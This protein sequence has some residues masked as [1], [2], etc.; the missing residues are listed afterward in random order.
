MHATARAYKT[1]IRACLFLL[2]LPLADALWFARFHIFIDAGK[3]KNRG[4]SRSQTVRQTA[5]LLRRDA[6][7]GCSQPARA[8]AVVVVGS[9][10]NRGQAYSWQRRREVL[11]GRDGKPTRPPAQPSAFWDRRGSG[12]HNPVW[13]HW[14]SMSAR[15]RHVDSPLS[16]LCSLA[17]C[18]PP[19]PSHAPTVKEKKKK[20][21]WEKNPQSALEDMK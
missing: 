15:C 3:K 4:L 9:E 10:V 18:P 11:G 7:T 13:L 8:A 6:L 21:T 5:V 20:K 12:T 14:T 19:P 2:S 16:S 1:Q 17:H